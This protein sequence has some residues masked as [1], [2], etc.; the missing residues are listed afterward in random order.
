MLGA[1]YRKEINKPKACNSCLIA[2]IRGS[3]SSAKKVFCGGKSW[4]SHLTE[5]LSCVDVLKREISP[6][7]STRNEKSQDWYG[8]FVVSEKEKW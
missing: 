6:L 8:S 4:A 3:K 2:F 7:V 1:M 5:L